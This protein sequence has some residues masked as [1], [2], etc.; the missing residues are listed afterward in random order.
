LLVFMP[1]VGYTLVASQTVV[2]L[3]ESVGKLVSAYPARKQ[4]SARRS[5]HLL[6]A[7]IVLGIG[8]Q[9]LTVVVPGLRRF[10]G[11]APLDVRAVLVL[12]A[13]VFATW[14]F[15][16]LARHYFGHGG[17]EA[18]VDQTDRRTPLMPTPAR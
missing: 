18:R 14:A 17:R 5:N 7:S 1:A 2:F 8:L 13:A 4:V 11:L 10:L 12:A 3:Y 16:M 6:H 15:S 9:A